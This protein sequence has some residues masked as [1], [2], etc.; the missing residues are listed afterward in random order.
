[1]KFFFVLECI[2]EADVVFLIDSSGSIRHKNPTGVNPG[3]PNDNYRLQLEFVVNVIRNLGVEL[4]S[5]GVHV[6]AVLFGTEVE[7]QFFLNTNER[8]FQN[9]INSIR[10]LRY[11]NTETNMARALKVM[12]EEQFSRQYG[13]RPEAPN[14]AILV[15]DGVNEPSD[16]DRNLNPVDEA[17]QAKN[18]PNDPI[19]IYTVGV[20]SDIDENQLRQISS[21]NRVFRADDFQQLSRIVRSLAT[22]IC[23]AVQ[24]KVMRK[25]RA[26][27]SMYLI[28]LID[29]AVR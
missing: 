26:C 11:M 28:I 29:T 6:G 20:T 18:R 12:R 4:E 25:L 23:E 5:G 22:V 27:N 7:N 3:D 13:D 1:M 8:R 16:A 15:T 19:Q 14:I 21:N 24:G 10:G 17:N 9:I 2:L